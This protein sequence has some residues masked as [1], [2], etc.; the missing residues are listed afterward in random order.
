M[1]REEPKVLSFPVVE[2]EAPLTAEARHR[3][4]VRLDIARESVLLWRIAVV[5]AGL[6]GALLVRPA[7][8]A[9]L[10]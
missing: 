10:G 1:S 8:L 6:V 9:L 7:L 3:L 4:E 2:R 5:V